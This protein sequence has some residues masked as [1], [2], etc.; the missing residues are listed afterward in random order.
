M[1]LSSK[2][3]FLFFLMNFYKKLSTRNFF[4]KRW[5]VRLNLSFRGFLYSYCRT[6]NTKVPAA[7][8]R[9]RAKGA[10]ALSLAKSSRKIHLKYQRFKRVL[11]FTCKQEGSEEDGQFKS[12][13][14]LLILAI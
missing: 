8:P 2:S 3:L 10:L 4:S 1:V 11:A 9:D 12:C 6:W 13:K 7:Q 14:E 5:L